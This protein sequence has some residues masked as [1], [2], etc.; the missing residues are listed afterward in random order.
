MPGSHVRRAQLIQLQIKELEFLPWACIAL[1]EKRVCGQKQGW[2]V[3][4][5]IG[6]SLTF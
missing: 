2:A 1:I 3:A 4:R 6:F 5:D